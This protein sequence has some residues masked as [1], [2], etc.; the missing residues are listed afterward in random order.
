[1][2][3][4]IAVLLLLLPAVL[5]SSDSLPLDSMQAIVVTTPSWSSPRG[6]MQRYERKG[7]HWDKVG[8]SFD[9][10][11]G[12][13]GLG[14][15]RGIHK[16]PP[17]AKRLKREGDGRAP[18]GIFYL[19]YAFGERSLSTKFPF[20]KMTTHH[21]C[22]DDGNSRYYNQIIDTRRSKKD[23]HS[24]ERMKLRSSSYRY[25]IFVAHNPRS[26][27]GAGSC[28]FI[29][30]KKSNGKPTVGCTAMNQD[31]IKRVITWLD[32]SKR[33]V[34]IQAPRSVLPT[35]FMPK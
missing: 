7:E 3:F 34:L 32:P 30:I 29:H 1:M 19:P 2:I 25:G 12:K 6:T 24:F 5:M 22:V 33:P 9:V 18:A 11:V 31:R 10:V 16:N 15:G 8:K 13:N 14:W 27:S 4:H 17:R 21:I 28:I 20:H 26:I 35:L 23:Y